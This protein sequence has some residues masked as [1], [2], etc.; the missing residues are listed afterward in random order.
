MTKHQA[1]SEGR[2]RSG[3]H[4]WSR[5]SGTFD[6]TMRYSTLSSVA[7]ADAEWPTFFSALEEQLGLRL[8]PAR[9]PRP[10]LVIDKIERPASPLGD[11]PALPGRP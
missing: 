1:A 10:V 4:R 3:F 11:P 7:P 5:G 8:L 2:M 6:I 9:E